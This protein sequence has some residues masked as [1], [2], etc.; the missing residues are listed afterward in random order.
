MAVE[1]SRGGLPMSEGNREAGRGRYSIPR[2]GDAWEVHTHTHVP[3]HAQLAA[4]QTQEA[5]TEAVS[6]RGNPGPQ[7]GGG[8]HPLAVFEF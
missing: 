4:G 2:L 6:V 7:G 1:R 3:A 8:T 5:G